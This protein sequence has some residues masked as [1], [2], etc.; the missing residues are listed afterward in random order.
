MGLFSKLFCT[1]TSIVFTSSAVHQEDINRYLH[2]VL[3]LPS[4]GKEGHVCKNMKDK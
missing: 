4:I 1:K 2:Y 3:T